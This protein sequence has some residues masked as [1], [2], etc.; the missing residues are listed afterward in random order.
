MQATV[1]LPRA[2]AK[3]REFIDDP[4]KRKIIR[5]GR[6]GGK[7]RGAAILAVEKFLDGKRILY[8][9]PTQDQLDSFWSEVV[10][11]LAEPVECG[12]YYKNETKHI[13]DLRGTEQ[14][15]KAK[16]A[17]NADTMRGDYADILILDEFQMMDERAW[18][19]VG[20]PMLLDNDGD[21]VFIYTPP[22]LRN[23][24]TSKAR[25]PRHA[26]KMWK[27]AKNDKTGRYKAFHFTSHDNPHISK[28][29]QSKK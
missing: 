24:S 23:R 12:A 16:T 29:L 11:A 8:A 18:S 1:N 3:Q 9:T 5:A 26:A 7:T 13:I 27:K 28:Q 6:R 25:D 20:A 14:R 19:E 22:S 15:I 17:Y 2:H 21:A 4:A 10:K